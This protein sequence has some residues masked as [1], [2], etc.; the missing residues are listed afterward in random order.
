MQMV[1]NVQRNNP[2]KDD[3]ESSMGHSGHL[4]GRNA[5]NQLGSSI[6]KWCSSQLVFHKLYTWPGIYRVNMSA[7]PLHYTHS[8]HC[9]LQFYPQSTILPT[10]YNSTHS[11]QTLK[12][13]LKCLTS[14]RLLSFIYFNNKY[15]F[16]Y[17]I[18]NYKYILYI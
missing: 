14:I 4:L 11:L 12:I 8:T 15:I 17:Y 3:N 2:S 9:F 1:W 6:F 18:F 13:P 16:I 5:K 7:C 10:V